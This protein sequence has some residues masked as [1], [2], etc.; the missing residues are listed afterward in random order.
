MLRLFVTRHGET[1]WNTEKRMQGWND[2]ELTET[3]IKNAIALGSRLKEIDFQSIYAS[4]SKR[5]VK[6]A[7]FII[8][9]K[10]QP[11]IEDENLREINLGEWEGQTHDYLNQN[12]S[13][14]YHAFWNT[15]HLYTANT[16]ESFSQL[17]ERVANF[18]KRILSE[19]D[20]GNILVVTHTVFIKAL[21]LHCKKK[22]IEELWTPPFIHDTSL[23]IIEV[24]NGELEIKLEGDITHRNIHES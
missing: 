8:G 6:T 10:N 23:T 11:I 14:E 2:S 12:Y 21:L 20:D 17:Q 9:G 4:P 3:G 22:S 13:K 5:T 15:P 18:L 16:G 24:K 1:I 19:H 7:S